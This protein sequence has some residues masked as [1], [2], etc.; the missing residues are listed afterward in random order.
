M[1]C[2]PAQDEITVT[3]VSEEIVIRQTDCHGQSFA[4]VFH[5]K[6]AYLIIDAIRSMCEKIDGSEK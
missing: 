5:R 1:K 3:S 4:V 6:N 2:L